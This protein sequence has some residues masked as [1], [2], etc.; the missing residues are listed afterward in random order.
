MPWKK[1]PHEVNIQWWE[2]IE[3]MSTFS[4][5][6]DEKASKKYYPDCI[7]NHY[8]KDWKS[9]MSIE[10]YLCIESYFC[11]TLQIFQRVEKDH[12]ID[13]KRENRKDD[14]NYKLDWS[15]SKLLFRALI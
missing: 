12:Q 4:R 2:Y 14:N 9:I 10:S 3:E 7:N 13:K 11:Y 6:Y 8:H 1:K 5:I 15:V